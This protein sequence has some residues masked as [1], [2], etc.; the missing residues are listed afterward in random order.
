MK[1]ILL[2]FSK[3]SKEIETFALKEKNKDQEQGSSV[4]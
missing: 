1:T 2:I 3:L 4:K